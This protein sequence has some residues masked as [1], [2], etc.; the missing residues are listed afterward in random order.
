MKQQRS[1]FEFVLSLLAILA[2]VVFAM[3]FI[4][5][6]PVQRVLSNKD[7]FGQVGKEW[8]RL[9]PCVNDTL[10]EF[11]HDTTTITNTEFK[12]ATDTIRLSGGWKYIHD[13]LVKHKTRTITRTEVVQDNRGKRILTDSVNYYKLA[14]ANLTGQVTATEQRLEEVLEE[15]NRWYVYFA[16]LLVFTLVLLW[17]SLKN[18][19]LP[20]LF[21]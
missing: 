21:K 17:V 18:L 8:E 11:I 6:N 14:T 15:R 3:W 9:N 16:A 10:L 19:N 7:K 5:C 2:M 12:L 4:S 20:K 1:D 13:T